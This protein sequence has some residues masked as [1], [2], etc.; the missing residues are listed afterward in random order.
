MAETLKAYSRYSYDLPALQRA[1]NAA[2]TASPRGPARDIKVKRKLAV[3]IGPDRVAQVAQ[4]CEDGM[5]QSAVA[6]KYGVSQSSV[7][8]YVLTSRT[9]RCSAERAMVMRQNAP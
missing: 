3:V 6:Q 1:L 7:S 5:S 8:K 4:D 2:R 9:Q